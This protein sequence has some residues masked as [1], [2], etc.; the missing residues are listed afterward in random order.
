MS[1]RGKVVRGMVVRGI[2]VEPINN[3]RKHFRHLDPYPVSGHKILSLYLRCLRDKQCCVKSC[4][5]LNITYILYFTT[6]SSA[7]GNLNSKKRHLHSNITIQAI[8]T[9]LLRNEYWFALA[10]WLCGLVSAWGK[11]DHWLQSH[12]AEGFYDLYVFL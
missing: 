6:M 1:F 5:T 8:L 12:Q 9:I 10:A 3:W 7:S 4:C 11:G 2:D